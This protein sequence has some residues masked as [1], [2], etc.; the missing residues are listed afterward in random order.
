MKTVLSVWAIFLFLICATFAMIGLSNE[1]IFFISS[2][3]VFLILTGLA[4][5]KV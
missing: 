1:A 4:Y 5:D 3:V 2:S